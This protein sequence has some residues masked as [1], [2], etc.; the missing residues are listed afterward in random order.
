MAAERVAHLPKSAYLPFG[1]G[2][3]ACIGRQFALQEATLVLGMLVQRFEL[4]NHL[5]YRLKT[6]TTLTV[7]P[8]DF[9]IQVRPRPGVQVDQRGVA[10]AAERTGAAAPVQA[11]ASHPVARGHGTRLTVLFG[12]NL[13]T[14]ESIAS[15]LAQEGTERGYDVTLGALD[16]HVDD[17]PRD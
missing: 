15:R 1:T 2:Q 3:R 14:A 12:S 6:R 16:D 4:V 13:G 5:G 7:K 8:D 11:P 9:R 17:L 10:P